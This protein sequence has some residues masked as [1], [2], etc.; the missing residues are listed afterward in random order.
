MPDRRLRRNGPPR[1]AAPT[2]GTPSVTAY[3]AASSLREGALGFCLADSPAKV[4]PAKREAG[5][6]V[7]GQTPAKLN[8][9]WEVIPAPPIIQARPASFP[10]TSFTLL[11]RARPVF[12]FSSGRKGENGGGKGPAIFM[13]EIS[14]ARKGE[15]SLPAPGS[16]PAD[17]L[18]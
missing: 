9:A 3:S 10:P 17:N 5:R 4:A 1:A 2:G 8:C 14:P 16:A 15:Q 6:F 11:D 18:S 12:S 13:A 7:I